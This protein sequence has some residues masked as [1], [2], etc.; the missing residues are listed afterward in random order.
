[1]YILKRAGSLFVTLIGL[2]LLVEHGHHVADALATL[3]LP[4]DISG[5]LAITALALLLIGWVWATMLSGESG[6]SE[7]LSGGG[8]MQASGWAPD[9]DL[10]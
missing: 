4:F 5:R 3:P 8:P 1:M 7:R 2:V 9:D 6:P 10:G